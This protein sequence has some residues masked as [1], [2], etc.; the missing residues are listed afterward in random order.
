MRGTLLL[1]TFMGLVAALVLAWQFRFERDPSFPAYRLADL[2]AGMD[3]TPGAEWCGP[4][5]SPSLKL[6]VSEANPRVI[7][8]LNFPEIAAVDFLHLRYRIRAENLQQGRETWE[9]GRFMIQWLFAGET[10]WESD[11]FASI[12][13]SRVSDFA[14]C[15]MRPENGA[16]TPSL[17]V[18]HLGSSGELELLNFEASVIRE[19][20]VWRYGRYGLI[21]GWVAWVMVWMRWMGVSSWRRPFFAGLVCVLMGIYFVIPG[22]WKILLSLGGTFRIGLEMPVVAKA[23]PPVESSG[24]AAAP[25]PTAG[26]KPQS[27]TKPKSGE[28]LQSVGKL[29]DRGDITLR[30]KGYAHHAR[31]LLHAAML[32][33]PALMIACLV[34]FGR[35]AVLMGAFSIAVE[36]AQLGFGYGFDWIDV[37][38]LL[39]NSLGIL[40]AGF[41]Y[42]KLKQRL[43]RKLA[44]LLG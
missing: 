24:T 33:A 21:A 11:Y 44:S 34:G 6:R 15:V 35:A 19:R 2:Q 12:R 37:L 8:R 22:P 9:D 1:A 3:A 13:E 39:W 31:P 5:E 17:R 20:A 4:P 26:V 25:L 27:V 30:I 10:A 7:V 23:S 36:T 41:V 43:P 32:F 14:E 18:E 16:A 40:G 42:W 38:D 28:K 29:P